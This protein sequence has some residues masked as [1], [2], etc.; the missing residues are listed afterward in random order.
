M[1]PYDMIF[2]AD[3]A[4]KSTMVIN[5]VPEY[6]FQGEEFEVVEGYDLDD[7]MIRDVRVGH[8]GQL[9]TANGMPAAAAVATKMALDTANPQLMITIAVENLSDKPRH[10]KIKLK[11]FRL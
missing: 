11:G 8:F 7:F 10:F 9:I 3:I 2:E 4:A 5:Q 1:K 6:T